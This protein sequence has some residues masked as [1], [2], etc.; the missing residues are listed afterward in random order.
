[1]ESLIFIP[2]LKTLTKLTSRDDRLRIQTLYYRAGYS[3]G[4]TDGSGARGRSG[5]PSSFTST[6]PSTSGSGELDGCSGVY[7]WKIRQ[8]SGL[9]L[10][11]GVGD[12][13]DENVLR[14]YYP[15]DPQLSL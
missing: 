9:V 6:V 15:G 1:M 7:K 14:T 3:L 13:N 8:G 4:I 5:N 11:E 10:G 12:N 2:T